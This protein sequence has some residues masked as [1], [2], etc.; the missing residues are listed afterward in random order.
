MD[1]EPDTA[2]PDSTSLS[3]KTATCHSPHPSTLVAPFRPGEPMLSRFS[4]TVLVFPLSIALFTTPAQPQSQNQPAANRTFTI[5]VNSRV[6]L[7]DVTVTDRK[8]NPVH[9]LPESMFRIFDNNQ[10]HENRNTYFERDAVKR[11][12]DLICL[13]PAIH[14]PKDEVNFYEDLLCT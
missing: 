12:I 9:G 8:G 14:L 7:T 6:V 1:R 11:D 13:F 3:S 2:A 4:S 5:Q 10:P